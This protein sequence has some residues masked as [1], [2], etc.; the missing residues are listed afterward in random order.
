M[1]QGASNFSIYCVIFLY[2]CLILVDFML[3]RF[4]NIVRNLVIHEK[5]MLRNTEKFGGIIFSQKVL[6]RLIETG[7]NREES[8]KIVQRN[9]LDAFENDG[10]FKANLLAD[11][12]VTTR[13]STDEI[14]KL[15]SKDDFLKNIDKIYNKF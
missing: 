4:E 6:L 8:Y 5:N 12:Q 11:P 3:N 13:L 9:A 15:F 14:E 7:L 1:T 10:D 2:M